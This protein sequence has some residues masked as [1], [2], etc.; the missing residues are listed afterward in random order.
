MRLPT[1]WHEFAPDAL[2]SRRFLYAPPITNALH[3]HAVQG[4]FCCQQT[5]ILVL[6]AS[7]RIWNA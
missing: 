3:G 7:I 6:A 1:A 4:A 5:D 2:H